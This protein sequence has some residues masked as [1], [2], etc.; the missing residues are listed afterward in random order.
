LL[1][2]WKQKRGK[3]SKQFKRVLLYFTLVAILSLGGIT[4]VHNVFAVVAPSDFVQFEYTGSVQN[5]TVP[6]SGKYQLEVWGAQGGGGSYSLQGGKGGYSKGELTLTAGQ[7]IYIY[8]GGAGTA[9]SG[10]NDIPGGYNGGGVA[11]NGSGTWNYE[12]SSKLIHGS[13]GGAT[14]IRTSSNGNWYDNLD[15]RIIIAGGGGGSGSAVDVGYATAGGDGGGLNGGTASN[16][17]DG[18]RIGGT[19]GTQDQGGTAGEYNGDRGSA[20]NGTLGAGG[21]SGTVLD[22]YYLGGAGGGGY[23]GGGGGAGGGPGGGGGSGYVGGVQ[24]GETTAGARQGNGEAKITLLERSDTPEEVTKELIISY[25]GIAQTANNNALS[26]INAAITDAPNSSNEELI[27]KV[28]SAKTSNLEAK[29]YIAKLKTMLESYV[30]PKLSP[31]Q[32]AFIRQMLASA[33]QQFTTVDDNLA[34]ANTQINDGK[35]QS[36]IVNSLKKAKS[37]SQ[38]SIALL[39]YVAGYLL[40]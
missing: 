33:E 17:I 1:V 30:D 11:I 27:A 8:V 19:G 6:Y 13:G 31:Q 15:R 2:N 4:G 28:N 25:L 3:H 10:R 18:R 21:N 40:F 32:L 7:S 26:Q 5:W 37:A 39:K 36:D 12:E 9:G 16:S 34:N 24:N 29:T 23:Y 38:N 35:P 22:N 14:D 20:T